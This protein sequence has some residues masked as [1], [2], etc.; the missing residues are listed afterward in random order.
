MRYVLQ[1]L[2]FMN[3]GESEMKN[4]S[5][6]I[7]EKTNQRS[8]QA[9][10]GLNFFLADVRAG[11]GP[12]LATYLLASLHWNPAQIG[13]VMSMMGIAGLL[14][15]T[16]CGA[17][18]D[19]VKGKRLLIVAAASVVGVSCISMTIFPNFYVI[20]SAQIFNGVAAAV[21]P[22]AI[23]AIT[24]GMVAQH[25]FATRIG[26][27]EVFNHAGNVAAAV[28]AG[29]IGYVLGQQWIFYL[30]AIIAGASA[31]SALLIRK[32]EI[33]YLRARASSPSGRVS[34][35]NIRDLFADR[36]ILAFAAAVTLFH[37]GNAA[38]LPLA[39]QLL[40]R[41]HEA[42][43]S[44][45]M[46][47]CIVAAQM[48]MVPVAFLS[49]KLGNSWGRK[50]VFLIGFAILPIRGLLY[51]LSDNPFFIVCVQL[52]DGIGA[53]IFGVLSVI[54]VADLTKG[55]GRYNLVLG[56]IA[57]AQGIGAS[58]SNLVSGYVVNAWGYN[59]GFFFLACVAA[60]ALIIYG[61]M[62][63]ETKEHQDISS[64]SLT[65]DKEKLSFAPLNY[66]PQTFSLAMNFGN[67]GEDLNGIGNVVK[68]VVSEPDSD[69]LQISG[70]SIRRTLR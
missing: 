46:S 61:L 26:R 18:V 4:P 3:S 32:E 60:V 47:A 25:E 40:T 13:V 2:L 64:A 44:I 35:S 31:V 33:D 6:H 56:A 49:G 55:T 68:A 20:S 16:P 1:A 14:A 28:L 30:V 21:F 39:G 8:L 10:D 36:N 24:L 29:T 57:T 63:P 9:L 52:L 12:F 51:T 7:V 67:N 17:L 59:A 23:A 45:N 54:V 62:M 70:Q 22:P 66:A 37:F 69:S 5:I 48:V 65:E 11:V 27:N 58:L 43:A 19:A 41:S 53:G 42:F 34:A 38:M 15:E 50:P